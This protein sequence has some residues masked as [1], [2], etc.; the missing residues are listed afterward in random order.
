MAAAKQNNL[1]FYTNQAV[2]GPSPQ[3]RALA[4]KFKSLSKGGGHQNSGQHGKKK[5]TPSGN[6]L[7]SS[8]IPFV[9]ISDTKM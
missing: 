7:T 8:S 4:S 3:N 6:M 5:T 2:G 9:D 1:A